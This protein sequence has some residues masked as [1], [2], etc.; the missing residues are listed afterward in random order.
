MPPTD[1][2]PTGGGSGDSTATIVG[3]MAMT[4]VHVPYLVLKF[5]YLQQLIYLYI[6]THVQH[7]HLFLVAGS[8][9][10]VVVVMITIIVAIAIAVYCYQ[11]GT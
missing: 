10:A 3:M 6:C 1:V 11:K 7:S 5:H 9:T 8:V 2:S 4:S